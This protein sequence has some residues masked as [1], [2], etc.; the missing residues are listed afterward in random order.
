MIIAVPEPRSGRFLLLVQE[1]AAKETITLPLKTSPSD[2]P[3]PPAGE[4]GCGRGRRGRGRSTPT[5]RAP[6]GT[7][8]GSSRHTLLLRACGCQS[9]GRSLYHRALRA[10]APSH[11]P[12]PTAHGGRAIP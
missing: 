7:D 12:R 9:A 5:G 2:P 10:G 4:T 8:R 6:D 11:A 3:P 1:K